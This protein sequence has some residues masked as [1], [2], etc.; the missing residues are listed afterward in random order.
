MSSFGKRVDVPGGRRR[1]KRREVAILGSAM[2]LDG[3]Q[4]VVVE[5]L[6]LTGARLVGRNLPEPGKEILLRTSEHAILGRIA[7][8]SNDR[9]GVIFDAPVKDAKDAVKA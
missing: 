5:D 8:A 7:W 1:I 9:R 6:C 4:S 3:S 2:T